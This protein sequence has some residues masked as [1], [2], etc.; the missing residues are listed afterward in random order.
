MQ[1]VEPAVEGSGQC[2]CLYPL[3]VWMGLQTQTTLLNY[4]HVAD[5][6][7]RRCKAYAVHAQLVPDPQ[8]PCILMCSQSHVQATIPGAFDFCRL[9]VC[10]TFLTYDSCMTAGDG[11]TMHLHYMPYDVS[12]TYHLKQ[13]AAKWQTVHCKREEGC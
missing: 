9:R 3:L 4:L 7:K 8:E 12:C 5:E 2:S 1:P 10:R 6:G 11:G 13:Q